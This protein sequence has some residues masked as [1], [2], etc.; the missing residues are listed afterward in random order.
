MQESVQY[1]FSATRGPE[2]LILSKWQF[3]FCTILIWSFGPRTAQIFFYCFYFVIFYA[4]FIF[5]FFNKKTKRHGLCYITII[6]T[7]N[8][9]MSNVSP[10]GE[11]SCPFTCLR[12]SSVKE[13]KFLVDLDSAASV[14]ADQF[15]WN[16]TISF[17]WCNFH[18]WTAAWGLTKYWHCV[19]ASF[20][21]SCWGGEVGPGLD[22]TGV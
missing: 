16:N 20:R 17:Q 13:Q 14:A 22:W 3:S 15:L 9:G 1:C 21:M 8:N 7:P 12:T 4:V 6:G 19:P 2:L 11:A 10:S 18:V 5:Y